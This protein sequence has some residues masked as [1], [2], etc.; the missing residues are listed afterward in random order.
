MAVLGYLT[1]DECVAYGAGAG[2]TDQVLQASVYVNAYLKRPEG[3][4]WA[5]DATGNPCYMASA[6]PSRTFNLAAGISPGT[7][8]VAPISG[9][10][11]GVLPGDVWIADRAANSLVEALYIVA[12]TAGTPNT[13]TFASVANAHASASTLDADMCITEQRH[14]PKGRPIIVLGRGP[15]VRLVSG[16]GR[17]AYTRRGDSH[18]GNTDDFNLLAI[19]NT[20]GGPP[21][22]EVFNPQVAEFDPQT[23]QL[24]VPSG[25][26]LAYYTEVR[27]R[28]LAGFAAASI[29]P[30]IKLATA[31]IVKA[32]QNDPDLG[33]VKSYRAGGTAVEMFAN[34][35]LTDDLKD[36][37]KPYRLRGLV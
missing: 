13:V 21:Q 22:W 27:L 4:I 8:V 14:T 24:W 1:P 16:G 34:T 28:Y 9:P 12:M 23:G 35:I 19:Y 29:P 15:V 36:M 33:A 11:T 7:N 30:E 3:L 20:F 31:K 2:S 32:L 25:I 17:Y 6:S 18:G 37:L 5:P 26:M 10:L